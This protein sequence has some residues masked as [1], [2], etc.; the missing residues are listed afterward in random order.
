MNVSRNEQRDDWDVAS[1]I[2]TNEELAD[3]QSGSSQGNRRYGQSGSLRSE[4]VAD[5]K[6]LNG[7]WNKIIVRD[8]SPS[9]NHLLPDLFID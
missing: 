4:A 3:N 9:S 8:M 6:H 5:F 2:G 7:Y 1:A